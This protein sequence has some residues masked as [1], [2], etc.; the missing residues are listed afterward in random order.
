MKNKLIYFAILLFLFSCQKEKK[1]DDNSNSY[2]PLSVGNYW[3]YDIYQV[4]PDGNET[5]TNNIDSLVILND[6][7]IN[8]IKYFVFRNYGVWYSSGL[9]TKFLRD[10]SGYVVDETGRIHLSNTDFVNE[11]DSYDIGPDDQPFLHASFKVEENNEPLTVPAGTFHTI[12]YKGT[13]EAVY[14]KNTDRVSY[15]RNSHN[16]YS[17]EIGLVKK[18]FFYL[19]NPTYFEERLVRYTVK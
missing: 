7:V 11:L 18:T 9:N 1:E 13:F 4:D 14:F 10:S 5:N 17:K 12:D 19:N 6:T 2:L 15:P 16:Y 3:I 8:G